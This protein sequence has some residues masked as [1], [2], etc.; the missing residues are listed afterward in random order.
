MKTKCFILVVLAT[1]TLTTVASAGEI[2]TNRL[3]ASL[4]FGLN[5]SA[6]FRGN[7]GTVL[8]GPGAPRTTPDGDPYNYDDGYVLVDSS[9]NFGG[10]TWYWGYDNSATYPAGQISDGVAFPANTILMSSSTANPN[11]SSPE[12]EDDP[13]LGVEVIYNRRLGSGQDLHYGF[14]VAGNFMNVSIGD[15]S[16]FSGSV[17]RTT[18]AYAYTPGTTPPAASPGSPYQGTFGGGG[19]LIGDAPVATATTVLP[20]GYTITGRREIDADLWGTRLGPYLD[21]PFGEKVNVWISGG[22]AIGFLNADVSWNE[23]ITMGTSSIT[24]VGRG[25]DSDVLVGWYAGGNISY[26]FHE[27]WSVVAG[28]HYQDLGKYSNN[29][30]GRT[31]ELNLSRSIFVSVGVSWRF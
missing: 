12:M 15:N 6:R 14:E 2:I 29:F 16:T 22:L 1:A 27:D 25:S 13:H 8:P 20:G 10:Q 18:D 30:G 5:I 17:T 23:T 9:G 31:V 3:T 11:F 19:F 24:S 7:A 21:F 28:V 4:R 26:D